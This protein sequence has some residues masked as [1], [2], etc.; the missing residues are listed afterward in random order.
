MSQEQVALVLAGVTALNERDWDAWLE[1]QAPDIEVFPDAR[2]PE[3]RPVKGRDAYRRWMEGTLGAWSESRVEPVGIVPAGPDRVLM[4]WEWRAEG[5]AS[6][7][8]S[9]LAATSVMTLRDGLVAKVEFFLDH[10][11]ALT[12]SGLEA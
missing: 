3:S 11:D 12:A 7:I 9:S 5:A 10:D 4:R 2:F 6:G 1:L 8:N